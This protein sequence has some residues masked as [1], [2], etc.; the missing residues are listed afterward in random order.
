MGLPK[1]ARTWCYLKN[2]S[3][4]VEQMLRHLNFKCRIGKIVLAVSFRSRVWFCAGQPTKWSPA[5]HCPDV[6]CL[7]HVRL[8]CTR[9]MFK[10]IPQPHC[11]LFCR[12]ELD[13]IQHI[14]VRWN[15]DIY[16]SLSS[17]LNSM[18]SMIMW[19]LIQNA[20]FGWMKNWIWFLKML[21]LTGQK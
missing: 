10:S 1:T 18:W 6:N 5:W 14:L 20:L 12:E 21:V 19:Y 13:Q 7:L 9:I 3:S 8:L 2:V 4:Q 15:A 11:P 16:S 17:G